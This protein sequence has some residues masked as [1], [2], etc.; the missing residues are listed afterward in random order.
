MSL[1]SQITAL[2][3]RLVTE[4]ND[5]NARISF[6]EQGGN[7][8]TQYASAVP[9]ISNANVYTNL[10]QWSGPAAALSV[11][12]TLFCEYMGDMINNSGASV[13]FDLQW[14]I[15]GTA[16]STTPTAG[17]GLATNATRRVLQ[18]WLA[19]TVAS[20]TTFHL[21]MEFKITAPKPSATEAAAFN[22]ATTYEDAQMDVAGILNIASAQTFTLQGKTRTSSALADI[23]RHRANWSISKAA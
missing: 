13:T 22:G 2:T 1:A 23:R 10:T 11:G 20:A 3:N 19:L 5:H 18:A 9:V 12:D 4:F 8:Q 7:V 21:S 15:A 17:F 16:I 6:L 14:L